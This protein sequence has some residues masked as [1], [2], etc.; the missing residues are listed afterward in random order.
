MCSLTE[1]ANDMFSPE[2]AGQIPI[3]TNLSLSYRH[4]ITS[5]I[6][7]THEARLTLILEAHV[8]AVAGGPDATSEESIR[9]ADK[10]RR[11][12]QKGR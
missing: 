4:C 9:G 2:V 6:F 5:S 7:T 10:M 12:V 3:N 1:T 11:M 8:S